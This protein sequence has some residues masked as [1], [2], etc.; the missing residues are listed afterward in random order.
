[1]RVV[2]DVGLLCLEWWWGK[3]LLGNDVDLL[4]GGVEFF[5]VLIEV[6]DVV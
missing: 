1:M 6:I 4:C 2:C 5:L 3:F